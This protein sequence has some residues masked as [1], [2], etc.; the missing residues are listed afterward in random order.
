MNLR[1]CGVENLIHG[2]AIIDKGEHAAKQLAR[3]IR[4]L[5]ASISDFAAKLYPSNEDRQAAAKFLGDDT[6]KIV[7][8]HPGSGSEKKNWPLENWIELGNQLLIQ[9]D[10]GGSIMIV[11][12]EADEDQVA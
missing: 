4:E 2:P 10:F 12:G 11:Y 5:G 7:A 1:R 8:F 6:G 3:P 9:K